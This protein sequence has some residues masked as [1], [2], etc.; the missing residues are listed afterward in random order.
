MAGRAAAAAAEGQE[1]EAVMAMVTRGAAE[2][3]AGADDIAEAEGH[4]CAEAEGHV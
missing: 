3:G 4:V 2:G 1:A